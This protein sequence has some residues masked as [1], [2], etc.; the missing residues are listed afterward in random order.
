MDYFYELIYLPLFQAPFEFVNFDCGSPLMVFSSC[1]LHCR[2]P[3]FW[4]LALVRLIAWITWRQSSQRPA[5]INKNNNNKKKSFPTHLR[6]NRSAICIHKQLSTDLY[7]TCTVYTYTSCIYMQVERHYDGMAWYGIYR[8]NWIWCT[9][10]NDVAQWHRH[11]KWRWPSLSRQRRW[12]SANTLL[13][14]R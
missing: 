9:Y 13:R 8:L 7:C 5:H 3:Y 1:N 10:I 12:C 14:P 4:I 11:Q 2:C 6:Y